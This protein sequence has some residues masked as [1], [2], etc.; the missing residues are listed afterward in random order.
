MEG[1]GY[2]DGHRLNSQCLEQSQEEGLVFS[3]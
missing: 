1:Q 2:L 3:H